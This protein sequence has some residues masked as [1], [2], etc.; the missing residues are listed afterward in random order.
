MSAKAIGCFAGGASE[1]A[2]LDW[3]MAT[4]VTRR[5]IGSIGG[6]GQASSG[7]EVPSDVLLDRTVSAVGER[8][9]GEDDELE[10]TPCDAVFRSPLR[11][12]DQG[13]LDGWIA[14]LAERIDHA[15]AH[16][17]RSMLGGMHAERER[18]TAAA[19]TAVFG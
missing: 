12:V 7:Y 16:G 2:G 19:G 18:G 14:A 10:A 15:S 8:L 13:W 4:D 11:A 9:V 5:V 6:N 1:E 3:A 17:V